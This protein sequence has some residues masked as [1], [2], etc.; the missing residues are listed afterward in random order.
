[1]SWKISEKPENSGVT[2]KI[3]HVSFFNSLQTKMTMFRTKELDKSFWK[4]SN[5]CT[6]HYDERRRPRRGAPAADQ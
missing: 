4:N 5:L 2:K 6:L 3:L 1:M